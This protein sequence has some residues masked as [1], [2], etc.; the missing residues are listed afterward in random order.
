MLRIDWKDGEAVAAVV[1]HVARNVI[2][3]VDRV[4]SRLAI[5]PVSRRRRLLRRCSA[6]L[7]VIAD[8]LESDEN[9]R[10]VI[11]RKVATDRIVSIS[12][13][14]ARASRKSRRH[15][16]KGFKIHVLGDLTR[17]LL[18][19]EGNQA[20]RRVIDCEARRGSGLVGR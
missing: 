19:I 2:D 3:V 12:D 14:Q 4:R 17:R 15:S 8:D 1:N 16:Y 11:T 20:Q 9:G 7:K 10:L 13:P 18:R 5:V 6:L